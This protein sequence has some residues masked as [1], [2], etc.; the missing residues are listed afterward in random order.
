MTKCI[1]IFFIFF[2]SWAQAED[3]FY[4]AEQSLSLEL[5]NAARLNLEKNQIE[6]KMAELQLKA[7]ERK[8][9]FLKRARSL[10]TLKSYPWGHFIFQAESTSQ[11]DRHFKILEKLSENDLNLFK[12]FILTLRGLTQ[13]RKDLESTLKEISQHIEKIKLQQNVLSSKES[14]RLDEIKQN[15]I[16]SLLKMKGQLARP[17]D[18]LIHWSYGSRVDDSKQYILVSKGLLYKTSPQKEVKAVGPGV[19]IFSDVIKHWRETLIIQHDDNYYSVYSGLKPRIHRLN[20][21][22]EKNQILGVT[23][24]DEFYFELRHF[25]NP[26]NPKNW[27]KEIL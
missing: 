14:K 18:S 16:A 17:L 5:D 20:E 15:N 8:S 11:L 9:L 6:E 1:F 7:K 4:Q 3:S 26:I 13:A 12:E 27:F 19:I 22:V 24:S 21:S 23:N 2:F 25:D 10:A